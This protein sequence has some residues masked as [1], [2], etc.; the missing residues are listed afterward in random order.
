[1]EPIIFNEIKEVSERKLRNEKTFIDR[2]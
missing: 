2:L 1:M